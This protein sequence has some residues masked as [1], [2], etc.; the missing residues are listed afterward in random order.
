MKQAKQWNDV[1]RRESNGKWEGKKTENGGKTATT[2]AIT[3]GSRA[4][5]KDGKRRGGA[6]KARSLCLIEYPPKFQISSGVGGQNRYLACGVPSVRLGGSLD[7]VYQEMTP[8]Y[9]LLLRSL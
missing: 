1:Y 3:V 4:K 6:R 5:E 9:L 2:T 7:L 8:T